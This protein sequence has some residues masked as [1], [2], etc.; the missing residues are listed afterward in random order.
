MNAKIKELLEEMAY[1][2]PRPAE[3]WRSEEDWDPQLSRGTLRRAEAQGLTE[4]D[5]SRT[6]DWFF[7][8]TGKGRDKAAT[9]EGIKA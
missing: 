6:D 4:I 7:R 9:I 1:E 3:K 8:F 2:N 5:R